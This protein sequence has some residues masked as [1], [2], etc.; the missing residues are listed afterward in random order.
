[1]EAKVVCKIVTELDKIA[2]MVELQKTVWAN[3]AVTSLPQMT[4]AIHHGGVVIGA[5]DRHQLLGF[6]YGF[7][8]YKKG[9][10]YL[11]SHMMAVHPDY[12]NVG[13]GQKLK[14]VQRSWAIEHGYHK[15]LWT[16]DPLET[17]NAYLNLCK[18]GAYVQR[19]IPSYYGKLNDPINQGLP[20]DRF[21]VEW[22]LHSERVNRAVTG[23]MVEDKNWYNYP[24]LLDWGRGEV[25]PHPNEQYSF[26]DP[27]PGY[28]IP[29]PT[30]IQQMKQ[31]YI[32]VAKNWRFQLRDICQEAFSRGYVVVGL[33]RS[34]EPV[35]YY[36]IEKVSLLHQ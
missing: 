15:I 17:R 7:A 19:Y 9:E 2:E 29:V 23:K 5:Y 11:F 24:R 27:Q 8:G 4:A 13:I 20:T 1:M 16:Y 32:E 34:A 36:V 35:H 10:T 18:L 6:C 25:Y 31:N 3:D 26:K 21:L 30:S 22:D 28:L 33:L 12:R 14:L